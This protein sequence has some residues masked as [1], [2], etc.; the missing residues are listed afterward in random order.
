MQETHQIARDSLI[1]KKNT[2]KPYYDQT[3]N[4]LELHVG[5]KVLLKEHNKK[6]A[7][8]LNWTGPYEI[9]MIHDNENIT[10]LRR[11]GRTNNNAKKYFE[12][13]L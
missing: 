9:I 11:G 5:D 2:N 6:N 1:E 3:T 7:L 8:C 12:T 13:D 4:P 10:I